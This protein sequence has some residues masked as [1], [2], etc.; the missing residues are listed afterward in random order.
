MEVGVLMMP[1]LLMMPT[2][3]MMI[4]LIIAGAI[5]A[6]AIMNF[7]GWQA[8]EPLISVSSARDRLSCRHQRE[9][10]KSNNLHR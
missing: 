6:G 7:V 8:R 2:L 10:H 3:L 1:S 9:Q 5:I 4:F